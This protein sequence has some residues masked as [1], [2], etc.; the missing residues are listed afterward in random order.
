MSWEYSGLIGGIVGAALCFYISK[1]NG[2]RA[3]HGVLRF[4][5]FMLFFAVLGFA[6]AA[7][8]VFLFFYGT[9]RDQLVYDILLAIFGF[10]MSIYIFGEYFFTKGK[11]NENGIEFKSPWSAPKREEW[12]NLLSVEFNSVASWYVFQ[13]K[14]GNAIRLSSLLSGHRVVLDLVIEKGHKF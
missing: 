12:S 10:G 8:G 9:H 2:N 4:G 14:S 5:F 3:P 13:F 6:I 1:K 7:L 11:F